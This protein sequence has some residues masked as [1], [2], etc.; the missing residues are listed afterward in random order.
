MS[1]P[2]RTESQQLE[3]LE[4]AAALLHRALEASGVLTIRIRQIWRRNPQYG[5]YFGLVE[6]ELARIV[7]ACDQAQE[8][9]HQVLAADQ[10][11]R[12]SKNSGTR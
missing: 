9:L 6:E 10:E 2:S 5:M 12:C 11:E 8:L 7:D 4:G 3:A 1:R